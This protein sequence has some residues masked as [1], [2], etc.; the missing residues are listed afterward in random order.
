MD[1]K[2][3]PF[4]PPAPIPRT[5]PIG[6]L[7]L[8]FTA[9]RN[10]LEIWG[11]PSYSEPHMT[12]RSFG[13]E[14]LIANDPGLVRHI[15]VDNVKNY[16]MAPI[17]QRILRPILR[18]GLLTAEGDIWKRSRKAMAPVFTPRHIFGFADT[19]RQS[20]M[21]FAAR[22]D[23]PSEKPV[24]IAHEMTLLTYDI[25]AR[26][27]FSGEIAGDPADFAHQVEILFETMGRVDP[28]D[29]IGA[30]AFLPRFTQIR[31][32]KALAFFRKIVADTVEARKAKLANKEEAVPNDFLSLLLKVEGPDGLTRGEIED[33]II[34]F[35]GAG[36]ETTARALGW[37]LY[38]LSQA[39]EEREKVEAEIDAAWDTL[40]DAATWLDKLPFTRA[41]FDEAMRLYPPASALHRMAI[42]DDEYKD[43]KIKKGTVCVMLPWLIHRHTL[44][45]DEPNAFKPSR[46]L[47]ENRDKL[48][49]YQ[50]IPFGLGPRI[51]IGA[52]F[53]MQEGVIALACLMK[54]HRFDL[55]EGFQP[56]PV[57][58]LTTQPQ[59]GLP[60]IV[61][62][63]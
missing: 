47:P 58:K 12:V 44:L 56:W 3:K 42:A 31:G 62:N 20:T 18:D 16:V 46:F 33:N 23:T 10:P 1:T 27:L 30:P 17:R 54:S 7:D 19:M 63:R 52:S 22:Y 24:D 55:V 60:M 49:R 45:W 50:Y 35:I 2:P 13:V 34:T 8:I 4:I 9:Y 36:H 51:C 29:L 26:T 61:S 6:T 5:K 28:F 25:L 39:P 57:Q 48:D 43:L 41:A 40:G 38:L 53:A 15:M 11:V 59:G 37:T 21:D 14:T 32:R